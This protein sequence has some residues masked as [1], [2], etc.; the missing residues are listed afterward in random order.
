MDIGNEISSLHNATQF[1][2]IHDLQRLGRQRQLSLQQ[3]Y[4]ASFSPTARTRK[5]AR[6][7]LDTI[8]DLIIMPRRIRALNRIIHNLGGDQPVH[9][10]Y[11]LI[12]G[13]RELRDVE[14]LRVG[15]GA[16]AEVREL[17]GEPDRD[18]QL[19]VAVHLCCGGVVEDQLAYDA[20]GDCGGG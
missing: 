1:Y 13:A 3:R 19:E 2:T 9:I 6:L 10:P 7:R 16:D 11:R 12:G 17:D 15:R 14:E 4:Y 5:R 20:E 8:P 18:H